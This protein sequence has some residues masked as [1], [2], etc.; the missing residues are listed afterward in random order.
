M[1]CILGPTS[2]P[3]INTNTGFLRF[4]RAATDSVVWVGERPPPGAI[5][6]VSRYC[7]PVA[8]AAMAGARWII[9]VDADL[10]LL[11]GFFPVDFWTC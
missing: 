10:E 7:L 5:F 1:N 6:P 11:A 8:D 9:S 4:A 2:T 3:W